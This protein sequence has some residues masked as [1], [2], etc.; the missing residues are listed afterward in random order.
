MD[1]DPRFM[2]WELGSLWTLW[3]CDPR[4][5]FWEVGSLDTMDM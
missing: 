2:V 1:C 4:Y 5:L 3:M